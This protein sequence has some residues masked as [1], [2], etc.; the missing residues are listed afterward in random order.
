MTDRT[1]AFYA[2]TNTKLSWEIGSGANC[3]KNQIEQHVTDHTNAIYTK[4]EA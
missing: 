3:D 1:H 2:K 4:N